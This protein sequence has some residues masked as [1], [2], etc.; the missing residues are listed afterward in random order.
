VSLAVF[1]LACP[2]AVF[3]V[4]NLVLNLDWSWQDADIDRGGTMNFVQNI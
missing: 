1:L 4:L 2:N 3:V